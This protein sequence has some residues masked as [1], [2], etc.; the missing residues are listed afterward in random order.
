[1][2]DAFDMNLPD[3]KVD[4]LWYDFGVGSRMKDF[5]SSAWDCISPGGFLLCHSTLTNTN[6]RA[7][8][9][10]LRNGEPKE[11]TGIEPGEY[12][13]LSVLENHKRFKNSVSIIQK[14][15]WRRGYF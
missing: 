4:I 13:E 9:E 14:K 8:L 7:W 15:I 5:I 10:A 1:M 2:G 12:A 11:V 6:T 3:S